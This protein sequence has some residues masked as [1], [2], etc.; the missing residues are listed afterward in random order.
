MRLSA[1]AIAVYGVCAVFGAASSCVS[2]S[3]KSSPAPTVT[4]SAEP[5]AP[6][7]QDAGVCPEVCQR[8]QAA[9]HKN[10]PRPVDECVAKCRDDARVIAAPS[11][12]CLAMVHTC[13]EDC[14]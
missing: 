1:L 8:A 5:T 7:R 11:L 10:A 4:I 3:S 2:T 14:N 12:S 9:C 13:N 6:L